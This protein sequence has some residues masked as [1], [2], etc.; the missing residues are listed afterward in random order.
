[1]AY[2]HSFAAGFYGDVYEAAPCKRPTNLADAIAS[3]E[4][5]IW[6]AMARD[7]FDCDPEFLD[8]ETVFNKAI[9]TDTVSDLCSPVNVWID[10]EG[11]YTVEVF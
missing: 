8:V 9:E 5:H 4:E 2:S 1:M 7:V 3:M 10:S 6:S 11:F